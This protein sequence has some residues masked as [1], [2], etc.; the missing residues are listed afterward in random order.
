M[1]AS[2]RYACCVGAALFEVTLISA[3]DATS[4][5]I[6]VRDAPLAMNAMRLA[7]QQTSDQ[8]ERE[9]GRLSLRV[10]RVDGH[11]VDGRLRHDLAIGRNRG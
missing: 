10:V 6:R 2:R 11:A 4:V 9:V 8:V 7:C 1:R 3:Q 5:A